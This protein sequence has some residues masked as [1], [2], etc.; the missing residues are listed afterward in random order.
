MPR[1]RLPPILARH[2]AP[3]VGRRRGPRAQPSPPPSRFAL[4]RARI[5]APRRRIP[6][7]PILLWSGRVTVLAGLVSGSAWVV[8]G[9]TLRVQQIEVVGSE[10]V[11]QGA[12]VAA[13]DLHG[14]S[15]LIVDLEAAEA[16][17]SALPG[18]VSVQ[19][20]RSWPH[21]LVATVVE[22][23]G[24]GYWQGGDRRVLLDERGRL[25]DL[26]RPA[27]LD[28]P[29]IIDVGAPGQPPLTIEVDRD[30]VGL[31]RRLQS[32]ER[33]SEI[34]PEPPLFVF[35]RDRGL[36]ILVKDRPDTV[37]G[38]STNYEF[39]MEAWQQ[40]LLELTANPVS[41]SVSE[42]DLRFGANVVMR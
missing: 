39:K 34:S 24:W 14:E 20:T 25:L 23:R 17:V 10:V 6:W 21:G 9:D 13:V 29:T 3:R 37:F 7:R 12:V 40:L 32:D 30:A 28:A 42:I 26:A 38:D 2:R 11:P 15:L 31:V 8:L 27:P 19:V 36:V 5:P 41:V 1:W 33:L 35:R 4:S 22:H 18:V 16:R